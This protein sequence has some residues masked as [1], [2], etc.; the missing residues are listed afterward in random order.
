MPGTRFR[1]RIITY[2]GAKGPHVY[3][4]PP[5]MWRRAS[6]IM[7]RYGSD[8][9]LALLDTRAMRALERGDLGAA[10]RWRDVMAAIH[11]VINDDRGESE[12][13]Q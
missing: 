5:R 11:A 6:R 4:M 9:A 1:V 3:P 7:D 10:V 8:E 2:P 13:V 12:P